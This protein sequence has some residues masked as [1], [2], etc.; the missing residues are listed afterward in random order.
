MK[1]CF[2]AYTSKDVEHENETCLKC[3]CPRAHNR[4]YI[5]AQCFLS[6]AIYFNIL[7]MQLQVTKPT[8]RPFTQKLLSIEIL[9]PTY[10]K[11]RHQ[12]RSFITKVSSSNFQTVAKGRLWKRKSE[13]T[14]KPAGCIRDNLKKWGLEDMCSQTCFHNFKLPRREQSHSPQP[15]VGVLTGIDCGTSARS[16]VFRCQEL[17]PYDAVRVRSCSGDFTSFDMFRSTVTNVHVQS[18]S[19]MYICAGWYRVVPECIA[20]NGIQSML[21]ETAE[22]NTNEHKPLPESSGWTHFCAQNGFATAFNDS[23]PSCVHWFMT[24]E[25]FEWSYWWPM[26]PKWWRCLTSSMRHVVRHNSSAGCKLKTVDCYMISNYMISSGTPSR[27]AQG[28]GLTPKP[29][30]SEGLHTFNQN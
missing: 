10:Q 19:I 12:E 6:I 27:K 5:M 20:Y 28:A 2:G 15:P 3:R 29:L 26:W 14:N 4:W 21:A 22:T 7:R 16:E 13:V 25:R 1:W 30:V 17:E 8:C 24:V 23:S 9:S 18:W 11:Q